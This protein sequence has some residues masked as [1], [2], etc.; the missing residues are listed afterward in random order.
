MVA[1]AFEKL[2]R[3]RKMKAV[4]IAAPPRVLAELRRPHTKGGAPSSHGASTSRGAMRS[5]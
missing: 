5:A 4:V 1:D 3:E 2:V